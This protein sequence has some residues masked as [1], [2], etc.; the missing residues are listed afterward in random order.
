MVNILNNQRKLVLKFQSVKKDS[1][2]LVGQ[3]KSVWMFHS[4]RMVNTST[5][6]PRNANKKENAQKISIFQ[7]GWRNVE[8]FLLALQANIWTNIKMSAQLFQLALKKDTSVFRKS[9][10]RSFYL[11]VQENTSIQK[12]KYAKKCWTALKENISTS[13]KKNASQ[14]LYA[15]ISNTFLSKLKAVSIT[16]SVEKIITMMLMLRD[17]YPCWHVK[18]TTTLTSRPSNASELIS[19]PTQKLLTSFTLIPFHN[20]RISTI[21][22]SYPIRTPGIALQTLLTSTQRHTGAWNAQKSTLTSTCIQTCARAVVM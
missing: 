17:A 11:V 13:S 14:D 3:R 21:R 12:M 1:S 19:W 9:S 2:T 7:L 15:L 22:R 8:P 4:A 5:K 10:V 20:T 18:S 6:R 16:Q